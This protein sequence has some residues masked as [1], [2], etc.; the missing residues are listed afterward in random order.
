MDTELFD[1]FVYDSIQKD[2]EKSLFKD[3]FSEKDSYDW[4]EEDTN[5]ND[6]SFD[7]NQY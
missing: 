2:K 4:D 7:D 6:E 5:L 1:F 3:D